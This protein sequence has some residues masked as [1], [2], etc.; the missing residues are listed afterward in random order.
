MSNV[1][2]TRLKLAVPRF[3]EGREILCKVYQNIGFGTV[4]LFCQTM[5][6]EAA[7]SKSQGKYTKALVTAK[8]V[9]KQTTNVISL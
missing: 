7:L 8:S 6:E 4:C 3:A 9:I 2:T 5:A 1:V